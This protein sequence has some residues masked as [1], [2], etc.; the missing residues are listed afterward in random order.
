VP[1][2]ELTDAQKRTKRRR[3][4]SAKE[5]LEKQAGTKDEALVKAFAA[6]A[7]GKKKSRG[8]TKA[9]AGAGARDKDGDAKLVI[10]C[11]TELCADLEAYNKEPHPLLLQQH[12]EEIRA[13][14]AAHPKSK[15]VRPCPW[16]L[17]DCMPPTAC[18]LLTIYYLH[19]PPAH[20]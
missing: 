7:L 19:Q 10:E 17:A 9:T 16:L 15:T 14:A 5:Y 11:Q 4:L 8:R 2:H 6:E 18:H 1:Y 12:V 13:E 20:P 3:R